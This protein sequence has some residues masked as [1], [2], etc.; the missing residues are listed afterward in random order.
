[1]MLVTG[2]TGHIGNVLVRELLQQGEQV[3]AL[4]LPG[5]SI[6]SLQGLEV[7]LAVGDVLDP[8]SLS[9]AMQ[10]IDT[11]Y[12]LAGIISIIPGDEQIM[13]KVN[14][15]GARNVAEAALAAGV[16]RM[17]HVSSIHAF[18]REPHG[19]VVDE[20][21]PFDPLSPAGGYDQTKA[22]GTLAVLSVADRGLNAV[23][24][25]PTGVIGP[26]DFRRSELG[27]LV[28]NF[29]QRK[30]HFLINGAFD[31]V[32]VRDVVSG[33]ILAARRGKP[34]ETYILSGTRLTLTGLR[35]VVQTAAGIRTPQVMVP[36]KLAWFF[37]R[38]TQHLYRLTNSTPQ[39]TT[40]SLQTVIDNCCFSCEKATLELGYRPRPIVDTVKDFL[41]WHQA[42]FLERRQSRR[43]KVRCRWCGLKNPG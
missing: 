15:E 11:V 22:E 32:D 9:Q 7:Q 41:N 3:R 25:C 26:Y 27:K 33:L 6:D 34:K 1:M 39:Y 24:V 36:Y 4:V 43:R 12:H 17:V 31:F 13:R 19:V 18:K 14:I 40:Y 21:T 5:E 28:L 38:F 42:N 30:L 10:G 20:R 35:T 23:I 37:S 16:R 29:S 8:G 2:S